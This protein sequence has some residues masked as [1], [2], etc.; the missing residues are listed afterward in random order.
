MVLIVVNNFSNTPSVFVT[1]LFNL[2][3]QISFLAHSVLKRNCLMKFSCV[4]SVENATVLICRTKERVV[5]ISTSQSPF[6]TN[7]PLMM[8]RADA[9][10]LLLLL[11]LPI[12]HGCCVASRCN[13][14]RCCHIQSEPWQKW[15]SQSTV[16]WSGTLENDTICLA[17]RLI[18]NQIAHKTY[19]PPNFSRYWS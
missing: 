10:V 4:V 2:S 12:G 17:K 6:E 5:Q 7:V 14:L 3:H 1:E 9:I 11:L 8:K 19:K 16:S 15:V 13:R 18:E